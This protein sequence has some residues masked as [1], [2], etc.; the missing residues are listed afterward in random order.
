MTALFATMT[1]TFTR[2]VALAV[3]KLHSRI[4][5]NPLN[6]ASPICITISVS[7]VDFIT[8]FLRLRK[9]LHG[10]WNWPPHYTLAVLGAILDIQLRGSMEGMFTILKWSRMLEGAIQLAF[11]SVSPPAPVRSRLLWKK[12]IALVG[13]LKRKLV[14]VP[15]LKRNSFTP[16]RGNHI[17]VTRYLYP[18]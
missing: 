3:G 11:I 15:S 18:F 1:C 13:Q 6:F 12:F 14:R 7:R 5:N 17:F 4:L 9:I 8:L 10:L 16:K 2:R